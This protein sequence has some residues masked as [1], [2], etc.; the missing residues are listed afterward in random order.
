MATSYTVSIHV[1]VSDPALL[2]KHAVQ[3][4]TTGHGALSL[5]EAYKWLGLPEEPDV[6]NCLRSIFDDGSP[7]GTCIQDSACA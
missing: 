6:G 5:E 7:P 2:H 1:D 3:Q 4:A